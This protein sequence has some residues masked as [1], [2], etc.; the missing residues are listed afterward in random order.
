MVIHLH[1]QAMIEPL[2]AIG[3]RTMASR[4]EFTDRLFGQRK[5][6]ASGQRAFDQLCG[7]PGTEHRLRTAFA[8][9]NQWHG[10]AIQRPP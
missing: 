3:P 5:R 10:R 7:D 6:A 2:P 8:P 9:A 4:K 1:K